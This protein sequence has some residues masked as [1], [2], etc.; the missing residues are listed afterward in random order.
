MS[1]MALAA[2]LA[3]APAPAA[4]GQ[5]ATQPARTAEEA[6]A[7]Y[8]ETFESVRELDCPTP[9]DPEEIVVCGRPSDAP[10]PNR[11]PL[12]IGPEPGARVVGGVPSALESMS[13]GGCISRCPQP[14]MVDVFKAAK[15]MRDLAER[16]I[17]G[18]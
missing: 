4:A 8:R 15:F 7:N 2:L 14:V 6:M 18:D 16:I 10:D 9:E 11:A 1:R 12:P 5:A 17:E 3:L 13:A